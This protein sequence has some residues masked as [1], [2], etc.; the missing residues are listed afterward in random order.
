MTPTSARLDE[1]RQ[2]LVALRTRFGDVGAR[3]ASAAAEVAASVVPAETLV[4][5]LRSTAADF[6]GLRLAIVDE[7]SAFRDTPDPPNLGT[8]KGLEAALATMEQAHAEQVR[9]AAWETARDE[10]R[11]V[12][13][14]VMALAHRE[15]PNWPAL[16]ECQAS[17][18]ELYQALD[19]A[20]SGD[21]EQL[22]A[23][24]RPFLEL[25]TL[26]EGWNHLDDERCAALQDAI[27][28]GFGRP[29]ALAAVRGKLGRG[30][31]VVD[32]RATE[33]ASTTHHDSMRAPAPE[34]RPVPAPID[35]ERRAAPPGSP[36]VVEI[37]MSGPRVQVETPQ[38]RREREVLLER[39]AAED[40]RWWI[41]AR[42]GW[43]SLAQRGVPPAEAMR[44]TLER[45]PYL[46]SVPLSRA[47]EF[48]DG[49]LAEGYAILLQRLEKDEPGFVKEA[50]TRLKPQLAGRAIDET[51]PIAHELYLYVVA[52]GRL[53]KTFPE[54]LR[55][56]L[57]CALPEPG[58]WLQGWIRDTGEVTTIV[59]R[60]E[61]PG[62][63]REESRTLTDPADRFTTHALSVTTGP[64]TARIFSVQ[65]AERAE[66]L[67]VE[68]K[69]R[70]NGAATDHAWIV[71]APTNGTL[72]APRKHRAGGTKI[73]GL[74]TEHRAIWIA[75]FNSDPH[76]DK[77]YELTVHLTRR[78][79]APRRP[80]AQAA[81][82]AFSP[83]NRR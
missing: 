9:R 34:P 49:R 14:R 74:G 16:A 11:G 6:D 73:A 51:Y 1:L 75:A 7:L 38:E 66:A 81:P 37:R 12:L 59:N 35:D 13:E 15:D 22:G 28:Q 71:V 31:A 80:E 3:A 50:L 55:D 69:L 8:L 21:I 54:M 27:T 44:D 29:L 47:D 17:A 57:S 56:A 20:A 36:L 23:H 67:D 64:L 4:E 32:E 33:T 45:F 39:L 76:A 60:P 52:E 26:A 63:P 72:E 82:S 30:R 58:F 68:I 83:F 10:A 79:S 43:A 65:A 48:E 77:T 41:G 78:V 53:Y 2:R 24:L 25:I 42:A 61:Q 70:E 62:D 5:D 18:R 19:G 40:A 46:F